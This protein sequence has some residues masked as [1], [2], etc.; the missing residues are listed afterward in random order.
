MNY[1]MADQ[2]V[3]G[4][5][6]KIYVNKYRET[7]IILLNKVI[8]NKYMYNTIGLKSISLFFFSMV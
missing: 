4:Y 8:P 2:K 3:P 1:T 5:V 6:N 7:S